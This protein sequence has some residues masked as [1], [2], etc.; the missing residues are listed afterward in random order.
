MKVKVTAEGLKALQEELEY[1]QTK[2][3]VEVG[4]AL[5]KA[6]A[7]GDLSE[8]S[9]Y[10]DAKNEQA[11]VEGRINELI[12][13]VAN[14]EIVESGS[15]NKGIVEFGSTVKVRH[16]GMKKEYVYTI[17]GITEADPLNG[18]ISNESPL[19][20]ALIGSKIGAKIKVEAPSGVIKYTVLDILEN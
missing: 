13:M 6:R 8:N 3:R 15:A 1:L 2:K 12:A 17:M 11:L 9:E 14:A 16:E 7:F 19:G 18:K 10:D 5:K 20:K 4:E